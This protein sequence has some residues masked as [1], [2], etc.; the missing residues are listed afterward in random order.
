LHKRLVAA[1]SKADLNFKASHTLE[2]IL[3]SILS[4]LRSLFVGNALVNNESKVVIYDMRN[5]V[6]EVSSSELAAEKER[7]TFTQKTAYKILQK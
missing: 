5:T 3:L 1:F 6:I 2:N 4:L 7:H